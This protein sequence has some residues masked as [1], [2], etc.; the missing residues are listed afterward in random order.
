[1]NDVLIYKQDVQKLVCQLNGCVGTKRNFENC[2]KRCPDFMA[3]NELPIV[4]QERRAGWW[5]NDAGYDKCSECGVSFP[6]LA[7]DFNKTNYCPNCG[8][9][10]KEYENE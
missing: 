3:V 2:E 8:V 4:Q 1:M 5:I 9:Q 6:D 10:M 7:P